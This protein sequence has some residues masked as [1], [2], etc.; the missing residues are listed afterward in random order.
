MTTLSLAHTRDREERNLDTKQ[1]HQVPILHPFLIAAYPVVALLA[2]NIEEVKTGVALRAMF[3]SLLI[4]WLVYLAFNRLYKD[5]AKAAVLTTLILALFYSYGHVYNALGQSTTLGLSLGRHRILAP[6]WIGTMLISM[7]WAYRA[8]QPSSNWNRP[9]NLVAAIAL[10]LPLAQIGLF[11]W[12]S[13]SASTEAP[14]QVSIAGLQLSPNQSPPDVY[15]IILDA[16]ARDDT[17][18]DEFELDNTPF[19]SQMEGMGFYVARCSQSNYVQTQLSLASALNMDYLQS[20]DPAYS[21]GQKTRVGIEELIRHSVVRQ[22]LES[23]GYQTIAF[24]TGFKGTQWED[25][26]IYLSP[27]IDLFHRLQIAGGPNGFEV[28]LLRTSAGLILAD[29]AIILPKVFQPDFDN[30]RK[31]HRELILFDLEQLDALPA[32]PGPKF[33]FAHLVIPHP[34]YVFGPN[35]EFTDYDKEYVPGYRDQVIYLNKRLLELL[36]RMI[37]NSTVPP[38]IILQGD[39]GSIGSPP[40]KRTTIFNAYYLPDREKESTYESISPVN[41]FRL[42]FNTYFGGQYDLLEDVSYYSIYTDPFDF[43]VIPNKRP[44]CP[45]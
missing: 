12:R 10:A 5:R 45:S 9:L 42:I 34:P 21:P 41:T 35:G 20:L 40:N 38:V 2:H 44:G 33:V 8:K 17:L 43:T 7:I 4:G 24:E 31:I 36:P 37:A 28:M 18:Q 13:I 27:S 22:A 29:G 14:G 30:P 15:Y 25:A 39:H 1:T 19:L 3:V 16:Y 23:L 26:D 32:M 11:G 6:I